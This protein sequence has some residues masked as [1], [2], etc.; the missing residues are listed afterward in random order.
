M[1]GRVRYVSE[2]PEWEVSRVYVVEGGW[3]W[4]IA[5]GGRVVLV[6]AEPIRNPATCAREAERWRSDLAS[7][8]IILGDDGN[9]YHA[10]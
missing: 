10:E 3:S 1:R 2:R 8:R 6:A 4:E 5:H 9:P 7:G